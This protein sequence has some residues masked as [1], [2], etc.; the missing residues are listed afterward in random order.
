MRFV[1]GAQRRNADV[2]VGELS[3]FLTCGHVE[4]CYLLIT[5]VGMGSVGVCFV[6][7]QMDEV[8]LAMAN[9]HAW[10]SR[11]N[12]TR[13]LSSSAALQLQARPKRGLT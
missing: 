7:G 3:L 8:K 10:A 11:L 12:R 4:V 5:V 13:A 6:L 9:I 1:G 2:A